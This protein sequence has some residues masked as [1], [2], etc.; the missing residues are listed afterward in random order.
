[1][2]SVEFL[3]ITSLLY[4][5]FRLG[6]FILVS[7]FVLS[8]IFN[9]DI[10]GII[11]LGMLLINCVITI[12]FGNFIESVA[13]TFFNIGTDANKYGVCNALNLSS[14]GPISR[15]LPLNINIFAFTFGYLA[16]IIQVLNDT[17]VTMRNIPMMI[18][19]SSLIL[20]QLYWSVTNF[21]SSLLPTFM[22]L[23][24]GFGFGWIFSILIDKSG[25][26]D[27]QYFNGIKNQDVCTQLSSEVFSCST[28][29]VM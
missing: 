26:A 17:H 23:S 22:S 6:P 1:M 8:S 3:N 27:L 15:G 19:F 16:Q 20:Y 2:P 25:I 14:T 29:N 13:P 5:G 9:S 18:M 21:C 12:L 11:F 28:Q 4:V 7:F 24:L 10:R